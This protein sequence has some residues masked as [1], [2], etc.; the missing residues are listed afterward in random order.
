MARRSTPTSRTHQNT[1]NHP[2]ADASPVDI[3]SDGPTASSPA[4]LV[5]VRA[6]ARLAAAEVFRAS[7]IAAAELQEN[8]PS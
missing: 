4:L 3:R 7:I 1:G 2:V 6:L 5:L 8:K